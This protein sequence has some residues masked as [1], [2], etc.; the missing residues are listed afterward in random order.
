V[1]NLER[2]ADGRGW[3]VWVGRV[4]RKRIYAEAEKGKAS[5]FPKVFF[6]KIR[7]KAL[8]LFGRH[9]HKL[10]LYVYL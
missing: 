4:L 3:A 1:L 6:C 7:E 8:F 10:L 5:F 9:L 2:I